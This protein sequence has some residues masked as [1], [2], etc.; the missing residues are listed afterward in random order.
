MEQ[1][2]RRLFGERQP[3][4]PQALLH[5]TGDDGRTESF[6]IEEILGA[7]GTSIVYR[8]TKISP[9]EGEIR[10]S[11]KEFYPASI[12]GSS[13]RFED[14]LQALSISRDPDGSL[15]L[16][17]ALSERQKKRLQSLLPMLHR[18]KQGGELCYFIPY[19]QL[20]TGAH[21][22]PYLFTPENVQGISLA[23]YLGDTYRPPDLSRLL[24]I[25]H[26]VYA[27]ASA[28]S[29]LC[30]QGAFLL[31]IKPENVLLV[32]KTAP[33]RGQASGFLMDAAGLFDVESIV[34]QS[35]LAQKPELPFS[36]G[37]TAPE[38][39]GAVMLPRYHKVGWASDV[40][41]LA[42]TL[43]FALTG[44][45]P[46]ESE[47]YE[48][49]LRKG[50]F[51]P[52]LSEDM[53]QMHLLP[54]FHNALAFEASERMQD[55]AALAVWVDQILTLLTNKRNM[56][57]ANA[58]R[59]QVERLPDMLAHLLFRWPFHEYAVDRDMRVLIAGGSAQ[60]VDQALDAVVSSCHVLR[61]QLHIVIVGPD[62]ERLVW[63]W[64]GKISKAKDWIDDCG[65]APFTSYPWETRLAQICCE[66]IL[67]TAE[68][69]TQLTERW[70]ANVV[71]LLTE[72]ESEG[73]RLAQA[74]P[75]PEKGKRLIVYR[76]LHGRTLFPE[77]EEDKRT[78][79]RLTPS[80]C[81]D[82]FLDLAGQIAFR[83]HFLY[84]REQD[85]GHSLNYIRQSY[86]Q[87]AYNYTSSQ[88]TA[89][90]VKCR[91]WSAGVPWTNNP[92]QDAA[93]FGE[94]LR[95][96]PE[97]KEQ[98]SWLEHRRWM[99]S[100]LVKSVR[101]LPPEEFACL[102]AASS[103]GNGTSIRKKGE[104]GKTH[105]Y[106]VYLMPSR[107]DSG[108][109]QGWETPRQWERQPLDAPLP[110]ELDDLDR[111]CV[112]LTRFYLRRAQNMDPLGAVETLKKRMDQVRVSRT[113]AE[114]GLTDRIAVLMENL[115]HAVRRLEQREE[116]AASLLAAYETSCLMMKAFLDDLKKQEMGDSLRVRQAW[117]ALEDLEDEC[118]ASLQ[119]VHGIDA[120]RYDATLVENMSFLLCG[121]G[122]VMGKLFSAGNLMENVRPLEYFLPEKVVYA[123][124]AADSWEAAAYA[125]RYE[126]LCRYA[127]LRQIDLPMELRLFAAPGAE[128]PVCAQP[129]TWIETVNGLGDTFTKSMQDCS[130]LDET[131]GQVVLI[132]AAAALGPAKRC[133]LLVWENGEARALYGVLP[134]L[135]PVRKPSEINAQ[136]ALSGAQPTGDDGL[137]A[138]VVYRDIFQEYRNILRDLGGKAWYEACE[139]F[140]KGTEKA[141]RKF[142]CSPEGPLDT[143]YE[144]LLKKT[145]WKGMDD[146][147]Q[148][149]EKEGFITGLEYLS[150]DELIRLRCR[151]TGEIAF[152]LQRF[153]DLIQKNFYRIRGYWH[154]PVGNRNFQITGRANQIRVQEV[155]S[156]AKEVYRRMAAHGWMRWEE[157]TCTMRD[158][159]PELDHMLRKYGSTLESEIYMQLVQ[160][161]WFEECKANYSYRWNGPDSPLNELD[162]VAVRRER[163]LL[164]SC[165]A[166]RELDAAMAYEIEEEARALHVKATPVLIASELQPGE[167]QAFRQRCQALGVLLIDASGQ[168]HCADL[169]AEWSKSAR[170]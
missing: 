40:Y 15:H 17:E 104:D 79:I 134:P 156:D 97:L 81:E 137:W 43:F 164:I 69:L 158:V 12:G 95:E 51:S 114:A 141:S 85:A 128:R 9:T 31:D 159:L 30:R 26:T 10:G 166:C 102:E 144:C 61:H 103:S 119:V 113:N 22:V 80:A 124:F 14:L 53:M 122:F 84:E 150:L 93:R 58:D 139:A 23:E 50:P 107:L 75:A 127:Q 34:M 49:S 44:E 133:T 27:V 57:K 165:K 99:A 121:G 5:L 161:G 64:C 162:V 42:A 37:F 111:A 160:S 77:E 88:D 108:R 33:E 25:L 140:E 146:F 41:A 29:Y 105:L 169:L 7:G 123:A 39:G 167:Q 3:L 55:P 24:Q 76:G 60:A 11:L 83:S 32:R 152:S 16:P 45:T 6:R 65:C 143:M 100:K 13:F 112:E 142:L 168:G 62:A 1:E 92:E 4:E 59:E 18:L 138:S 56:E 117:R 28:D 8:V 35:E 86:E 54:L 157:E 120:K 98:I 21:G 125:E 147:F 149:L 68:I 110:P 71:L 48:D 67:P 38:L 94:T 136:F 89:L 155:S 109:P 52:W 129:L 78:V 153:M 20:Y 96:V 90:A 47:R 70:K 135:V 154:S 2:I 115:E 19:M 106:H 73:S 66:N 151:T 36:S 74:V 46:A 126:N 72:L 63:N 145:D 131:G 116:S 82:S 101:P 87:D 163:L 91:L 118:F 148:S 132:N 130:V 170:L